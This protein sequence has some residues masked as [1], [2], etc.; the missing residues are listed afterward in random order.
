MILVVSLFDKIATVRLSYSRREKQVEC[1]SLL[2]SIDAFL[3]KEKRRPED[4]TGIVAILGEAP[5]TSLRQVVA[6]LNTLAFALGIKIIAVPTT[7][8]DIDKPIVRGLKLLVKQKVG[9]FIK[10]IYSRPPNITKPKYR[11]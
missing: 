7:A 8:G 1:R 6:A 11:I 3:K 10:P 5:F 2:S 9:R 4:I